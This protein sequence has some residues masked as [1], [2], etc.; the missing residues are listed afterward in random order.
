MISVIGLGELGSE[1]FK[2]IANKEKDVVGVDVDAS[3][4]NA[5]KSGVF[6]VSSEAPAS[7]VYVICVYLS[8]QVL[9]VIRNLDYSR[10][11]LVVVESTLVPGTCRKILDFK[12]ENNLDFDFVYFGHRFSQ[13]DP[14][15]HIFNQ[16]RV[17]GG[18]NV[19]IKRATKFFSQFM[20]A[21]L[22]H[23]TSVGIAELSKPLENAYRFM[24]IAFAEQLKMLCSKKGIDFEQLRYAVNTKWNIG[25]KE[26]HTG[27]GGR[28]L[29][30]DTKIINE[31]FPDN[32]M[33]KAAI[34]IDEE[35]KKC[36]KQ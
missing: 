15:H 28:C 4:L 23:T 32:K 36:Q 14:E 31:F 19:S 3:R 9:E 26:V 13:N 6:N 12:N 16:P 34:E 10:N 24:E 22:I 21:G 8:E 27:I 5:L 1:V 25:I 30:K 7:D 33:I 11:P 18:D 2:E 17:M 20:D 29:P 35:Y